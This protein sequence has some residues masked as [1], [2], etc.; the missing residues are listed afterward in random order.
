MPQ[1]GAPEDEAAGAVPVLDAAG[2]GGQRAA[3][4]SGGGGAAGD[5]GGGVRAEAGVA[6][7]GLP[8]SER[9]LGVETDFTT[10]SSLPRPELARKSYPSHGTWLWRQ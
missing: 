2:L 9:V 3:L 8:I 5:R 7:Q 4:P 6:V 10:P 1:Q